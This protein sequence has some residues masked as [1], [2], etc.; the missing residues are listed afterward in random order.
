MIDIFC[1]S[2]RHGFCFNDA[3]F[4]YT[5]TGHTDFEHFVVVVDVVRTIE[6]NK[7]YLRGVLLCVCP[8]L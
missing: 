5:N 4:L 1:I 3:K 2:V 8:H 7:E 6:N